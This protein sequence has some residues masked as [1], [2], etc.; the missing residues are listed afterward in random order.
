MS[1]LI[2]EYVS[3]TSQRLRV[4]REAGVIRG[5]KLL[6]LASRNG[7]RYR[8]RALVDAISLYEGAKV[9]IN[10][11]KGNPLAP[12]DYQDRLGMVRDVRFRP[13][14]GLFGD[15]HFNPRHALSEQLVWDAEN[16]PQN[17]GMSHNVLAR[18]K[19]IGDDTFVEAISKVQSIDLVAD[20]ATTQGLYEHEEGR[21]SRVESREPAGGSSH[22]AL[23]TRP[24]SLDSITLEQL[25]SLR[26]DLV[27]GIAES[28]ESEILQL[29]KQ[30]DD[31]AAREATLRR[32]ELVLEV[33][34]EHE[35]PL[36][37]ANGALA[38]VV[39]TPSFIE[40]LMNAADEAGV[41]A[42]V[43]ERAKVVRLAKQLSSW[44]TANEQRPRSKSQ[45]AI[46]A[47]MRTP[48]VRTAA[49]FAAAVRR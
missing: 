45:V 30:L 14:E 42:L 28:Y 34:Q 9:N 8:E 48:P 10:H 31:V 22:S 16:A 4:D 20:P 11:P 23:D 17:V 38:A 43:E 1:E 18:T 33:L 32:R 6:G 15:L 36:P 25:R 47:A 29:Q 46:A 21:G 13:G 3:S 37:T 26:P 44:Q 35:L 19:Q 7:R 39:T 40:S 27:D 41:R 2:Q 49:E 24:S 5:V 12:R